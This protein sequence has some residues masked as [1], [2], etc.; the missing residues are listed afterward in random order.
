MK[1]ERSVPVTPAD[2]KKEH[3]EMC[4]E[5]IRGKIAW[6]KD[7]QDRSKSIPVFRSTIDDTVIYCFSPFEVIGH[8]WMMRDKICNEKNYS[9]DIISTP[10][11][12][13]KQNVV[14]NSKGN[15]VVLYKYSR[16]FGWQLLQLYPDQEGRISSPFLLSCA[17]LYAYI[18]KINYKENESKKPRLQILEP[19][20]M[21]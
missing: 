1:Q 11:F 18:D 3:I 19:F 7:E 14:I 9:I 8:A 20:W 21:I 4:A 2:V 15:I 6:V 13:L 16:T 17:A 10:Y 12:P 5:I